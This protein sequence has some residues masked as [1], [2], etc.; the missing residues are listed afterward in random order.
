MTIPS[1]PSFAQR[2][3]AALP[4]TAASRILALLL[5]I[6]TVGL[7]TLALA[8]GR[9][10]EP[11]GRDSSGR[12][13]GGRGFTRPDP[14]D[15][16]QRMDANNNGILEPSEI[17][18]RSR[19]FLDGAARDGGLDLSRGVPVQKMIEA[20]E[21]RNAA[22]DS[23]GRGGP[24][25]NGGS[26]S[27]GSS[28]SGGSS[29]GG[30]SGSGSGRGS[31]FNFGAPSG[32]PRPPGF[33]PPAGSSGSSSSG[34]SSSGSGSSG[35]GGSTSSSSGGSSRSS[36]GGSS[37]A[38]KVR[39]YASGL[40]RQ[41]DKNQN[42]VLDKEEWESVRAISKDTDANN[43]GTVTL[44]ELT[45]KLGSFGKEEG[46]PSGSSG[47]SGG[48]SASSGGSRDGGGRS[49][50]GSSRSESKSADKKSYRQRT[51]TERLPK[52]LPDWFARN[53]ADGDGQVVMSEY[54]S[55]WSE[56]KAEEF[57][58]YDLDGDGVITPRECLRALEMELSKK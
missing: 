25:G 42:G 33:A 29:S 49:S 1:P 41:H 35:S 18:E 57:A 27:G 51:P 12:D 3:R 43:D 20:M 16:I 26:S 46:K 58:K 44:D 4:G 17:S 21:K 37:E 11:G 38:Q 2:R 54:A 19:F 50:G 48:G 56:S 15:F 45:A 34:R 31:Q 8:Q 40:L 53:D 9:D 23:S 22:R 28:G 6:S 36:S 55:L 47:S 10:G 24:P 52:G 13:R 39:D 5:G 14:K 32:P 7:T 30:S